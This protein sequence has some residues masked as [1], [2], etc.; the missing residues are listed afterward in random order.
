MAMVRDV[1]PPAPAPAVVPG[2]PG[3]AP[4]GVAPAGVPDDPVLAALAP[5]LRAALRHAR[6]ASGPAP[7]ALRDLTELDSEGDAVLAV[8]RAAVESDDAFRAAVAAS[9]DEAHV[10]ATGWAWLHRLPGWDERLIDVVLT[11][12][13]ASGERA[14][15]RELRSV[16]RRLEA[17]ERRLE[18][19]RSRS[20]DV[21]RRLDVVEQERAAA[22]DSAARW[23]AELDER[24]REA[25][26][27]RN[28]LAAALDAQQ[29]SEAQ[30][31]E[32]RAARRQAEARL[33]ETSERLASAEDRARFATH[34]ARGGAGAP[35]PTAAPT[36]DREAARTPLRLDRGRRED[37]PDGAAALL[38]WPGAI[39]LVDGYNVS[40]QGWPALEARDQRARLVDAL[41]GWCRQRGAAATVV[42]DGA[43]VATWRTRRRVLTHVEVVFSADGVEADDEILRRVRRVAST[44]PVVVV[45]TDGRVRAGSSA[46]GANVVRSADLLAL[47]GAPRV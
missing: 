25:V 16:T 29:R 13:H 47:L 43:D 27:L 18:R 8:V 2:P 32:E 19:A 6:S 7:P 39:V 34:L 14:A 10:G 33:T 15:A 9:T 40:M 5:A 35:G 21:E 11:A 24:E 22:V 42:F 37:T 38:A 23:R 31:G 17:S 4:A 41:D 26:V 1:G 36:G 3:A 45:S 12:R 46:A 30:L 20:A 28:R 44:T